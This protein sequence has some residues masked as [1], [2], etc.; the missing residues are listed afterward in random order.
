M[1]AE[2]AFGA[3]PEFS[4]HVPVV[5]IGGGAC[6]MTAAL[7]ARD[8]GAQVLVVERDADPSGSTALSS[9][10][11]PA[12]ATRWQTEAGVPDD[13]ATMTADVLEKCHH[14]TDAAYAE[15]VCAASGPVLEWLADTHGL[16]FVLVD[17]FTYPGHSALRMHAHPERTGRALI[18]TLTQAAVNAEVDVL[19]NATARVLLSATISAS[20]GSKSNVVMAAVN[21][22][23]A[24]HWCSRV[25]D[26]VVI[27]NS[28]NGTFPKWPKRFTL[29]IQVIRATRLFG[30]RP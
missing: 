3:P 9:G 12:C 21:L 25:M 17:G 19:A 29:D 4:V 24:G 11:V 23:D 10:F 7:A 27:P 18:S 5:I 8:V 15:R 26:T 22:S 6:G 14:Q 16:E 30:A 20:A 13:V 1:T 2:V 28:F